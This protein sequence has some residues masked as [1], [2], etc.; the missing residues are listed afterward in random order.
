MAE[1]KRICLAATSTLWQA[2]ASSKV[3]FRS[4]ATVRPKSIS[5]SRTINHIGSSS[6][7]QSTARTETAARLLDTYGNHILR[8]AYTYVHNF[9]D[10]EDILQ[11]TLVQY[12]KTT[13][14][15]ES[16]AH[17]KA[18][19]LRTAANLSKNKI[20]YNRIRITDELNEELIAEEREDLSFVWEAVSQL[21]VAQREIIHLFY[22][23]GYSTAQIAA[24]VGR[25]ES[26]V[27]SDLTRARKRL[28]ILLKEAYDFA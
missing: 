3:I 1:P 14:A 10:A 5:R 17:E 4:Q 13:P 2:F 11:D 18:W 26:T 25:G 20:K 22:E 21:P 16:A 9:S 12:L 28:K 15:F 19:L 7:S 27:R 6:Q 23:E 8:L 24:I